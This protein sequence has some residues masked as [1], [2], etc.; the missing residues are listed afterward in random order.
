MKKK[1]VFDGGISGIRTMA[2][3]SLRIQI[4][5]QE[6]PAEILTRVFELRNIPGIVLVST[7]KITDA[8]VDA[9]SYATSDFGFKQKTHSQRLRSVIYR[10]WEQEA[11]EYE[12]DVYY[13]NKMNQLINHYKEKLN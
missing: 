3:G 13:A 2:D 7:D 1:V 11:K 10:L 12:F 5:T 8:E 4:D 9:V 6:L